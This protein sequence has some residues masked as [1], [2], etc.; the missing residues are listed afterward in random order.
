MFTIE[1]SSTTINWA[2]AITTRAIQRFGSGVAA[3]VVGFDGSSLTSGFTVFLR[4]AGGCVRTAARHRAGAER[5][6][7][8]SGSE[9]DHRTLRPCRDHTNG[10]APPGVR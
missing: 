2:I 5:I 8:R 6:V 4:V 1:A 3:D 10:P 7:E 9:L